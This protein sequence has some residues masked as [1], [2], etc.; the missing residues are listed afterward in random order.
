M[1]NIIVIGLGGIGKWLIDPLCLRLAHLQSQDKNP[2]GKVVLVDA[3]EYKSRKR[4]RQKFHREGNKVEVEFERLVQEF[5]TLEFE[6]IPFYVKGDLDKPSDAMSDRVINVS[7]LIHDDDW[8]ILCVDNPTTRNRVDVHC[9]TLRTVKL[10]NGGNN[11]TNG[12]SMLYIRRGGRD[13]TPP[14]REL[15]P[16]TI[17][18]PK[19]KA[20]Y[21]MSCEELEAVG[22]GQII[23][24]NLFAATLLYHL[25]DAEIERERIPGEVIYFDSEKMAVRSVSFK[26]KK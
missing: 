18:N 8:V 14:L 20:P 4:I 23:R 21:E 24:A 17:G 7:E 11:L 9:S 2:F 10:F 16:D 13:I 19:S 26:A 3:G 25:I 6:Q 15:F 5:P 12:A 22:G 1:G